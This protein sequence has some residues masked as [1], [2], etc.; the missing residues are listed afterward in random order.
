MLRIPP[1]RKARDRYKQIVD[2]LPS[3]KNFITTV[4]LF[5]LTIVVSCGQRSGIHNDENK[6]KNGDFCGTPKPTKLDDAR[7]EKGRKLYKQNCAICH[8]LSS[9]QDSYGNGLDKI[10]EHVPSEDWFIKY[11]LN[12]EKVFLSGDKYAKEINERNKGAM[13]VFEGQLSES[14]IQDIIY[15]IKADKK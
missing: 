1:E 9:D 13:T 15:Y 5:T 8:A 7:S 4:V 2:R 6:I 11:T 12:N 10:L 3:N 14:D